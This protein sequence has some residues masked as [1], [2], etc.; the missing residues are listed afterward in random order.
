L[1][2]VFDW[3]FSYGGSGYDVT[4]YISKL[5]GAKE[6][7]MKEQTLDE[8]TD[9]ERYRQDRVASH[10]LHVIAFSLAVSR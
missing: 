2:I 3:K 4:F 7:D 9:P 6:G 5:P 8:M 10:S 1:F